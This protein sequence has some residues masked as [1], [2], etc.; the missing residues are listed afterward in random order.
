MWFELN[1]GPSCVGFKTVKAQ[2]WSSVL[3]NETEMYYKLVN[4]WE[5]HSVIVSSVMKLRQSSFNRKLYLSI[6]S[7]HCIVCT[8]D[9]RYELSNI[10]FTQCLV[11][12][13][14]LNGSTSCSPSSNYKYLAKNSWYRQ[15]FSDSNDYSNIYLIHRND[16]RLINDMTGDE[17]LERKP[18]GVVMWSV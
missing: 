14:I 12:Q 15:L 11:E 6:W 8:T 9:T 2:Q 10:K 3:R 7:F 4:W 5:K 13:T 1:D 16:S 17:Q 18:E